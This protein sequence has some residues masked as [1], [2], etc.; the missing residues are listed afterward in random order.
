MT[1]ES[2]EKI[3]YEAMVSEIYTKAGNALALY[4]GAKMTQLSAG[5]EGGFNLEECKSGLIYD[6]SDLD[7][8][9]ALLVMQCKQRARLSVI[10]ILKEQIDPSEEEAYPI[11]DF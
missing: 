2:E 8:A 7:S 6:E 11:E 3:I 1:E 5:K 10:E 4:I 9:I